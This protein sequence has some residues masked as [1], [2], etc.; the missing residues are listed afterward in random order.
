MGDKIATH[1]AILVSW[2]QGHVLSRR[3]ERDKIGGLDERQGLESHLWG[4]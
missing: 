2:G 3:K 1:T 4:I